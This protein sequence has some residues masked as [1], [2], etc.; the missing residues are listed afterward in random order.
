VDLANILNLAESAGGHDGPPLFGAWVPDP[1]SKEEN[2]LAFGSFLP[3]FHALGGILNNWM[4]YQ[5]T[6]AQ[7][8]RPLLDA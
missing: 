1:F 4:A 7:F 3:N 6:R 8:A 5:A 2:G